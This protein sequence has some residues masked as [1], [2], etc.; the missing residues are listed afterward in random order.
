MWSSQSSTSMT[1]RAAFLGTLCFALAVSAVNAT[2]SRSLDGIYA[3]A[4]RRLPSHAH[5]FSFALIDGD[6]DAFVVSDTHENGKHVECT[7][8]NACARGL[9]T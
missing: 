5:S 4:K 9:Y 8:V 3:L 2:A 6:S 7:T 1:I